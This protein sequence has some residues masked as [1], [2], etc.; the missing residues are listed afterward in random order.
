MTVIDELHTLSENKD[1]FDCLRNAE[2]ELQLAVIAETQESAIFKKARNAIISSLK[3]NDPRHLDELA[4]QASDN[5]KVLIFG[6]TILAWTSAQSESYKK[7]LRTMSRQFLDVR[8]DGI[9]LRAFRE[10][11]AILLQEMGDSITNEQRLNLRYLLASHTDQCRPGL[12]GE[13]FYNV[14]VAAAATG[15]V[16]KAKQCFNCLRMDLG[17]NIRGD[18]PQNLRFE[19]R[20]IL[21][22]YRKGCQDLMS[23]EPDEAPA[24]QAEMQTLEQKYANAPPFEPLGPMFGPIAR[25]YLSRKHYLRG[26]LREIQQATSDDN[27]ASVCYRYD[28]CHDIDVY[29]FAIERFTMVLPIIPAGVSMS[30]EPKVQE[31]LDILK[32]MHD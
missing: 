18:L 8:P 28:Y 13:A 6:E 17:N 16:A 27:L 9:Y 15:D 1:L 21:Y 12:V 2:N 32:H 30:Y 7:L 23:M 11:I 26:L 5:E 20:G 3:S 31:A 25:T 14:G 4:Q 19:V 10:W 29:L 24:I 22:W